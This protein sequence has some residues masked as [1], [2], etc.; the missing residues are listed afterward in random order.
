MGWEVRNF[1]FFEYFDML[2]L[3]GKIKKKML[4]F[5]KKNLLKFNF[6]FFRMNFL[7]GYDEICFFYC[8]LYIKD[9]SWMFLKIR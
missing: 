7:I 9:M 4:V 3:F 6:F 2:N 8:C 5:L 1:F